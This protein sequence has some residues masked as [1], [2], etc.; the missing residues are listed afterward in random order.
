VLGRE[1]DLEEFNLLLQ[2]KYARIKQ[3]EER[4]QSF[5][6]EDAKTVLVAYGTMARIARAAMENLR[7]KGIKAGL[8][9]P[10]TLWP[11]PQKVFKR[12]AKRVNLLAVE[13]S[14]GQM[15]E[16]VRLAVGKEQKVEFLGRSG[17]GVPSEKDI[18]D[19]VVR[20]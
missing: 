3:K 18:I 9:R 13:M 2:K 12:C 19:T 17:G 10:V 14:Y 15:V 4:A 1:G 8:I 20:G 5:N 16:D 7:K 6:L 11:F